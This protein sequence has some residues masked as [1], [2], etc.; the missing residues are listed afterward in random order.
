[1]ADIGFFPIKWLERYGESKFALPT[2]PCVHML[3]QLEFSSGSLGHGLGVSTGIAY[4]MKLKG[5][6][7]RSFVLMSDGECNEGS[8]WEAVIFA[9]SKK[10]DN[11][12][13][14]ID[15][16]QIQAVGRTQEIMGNTSLAKKFKSFGW[17]T[18]T[19]DGNNIE[20]VVKALSQIDY[21]TGQPNVIV[22]NTI[23]GAGVSFMEDQLLWHYRVPSKED[24]EMALKE[25]GVAPLIKS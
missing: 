10:L 20:E 2:H 13:A 21:S 22:C 24:Y 9:A 17:K 6:D 18:Y 19:I 3:P 25:L 7:R 23:A 11:L 15:Y 16:N 14:L 8:V 4:G 1:M 12:V 5:L